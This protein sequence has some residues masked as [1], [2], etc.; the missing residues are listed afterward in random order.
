[1]ANIV[2][3]KHMKLVIQSCLDAQNHAESFLSETGAVPSVT[4]SLKM[5][6]EAV[7]WASVVYTAIAT[8]LTFSTKGLEEGSR[9]CDKEDFELLVVLK[10]FSELYLSDA[11]KAVKYVKFQTTWFTAKLLDQ[12]EF[13]PCP[14]T[15]TELPV[16]DYGF[17]TRRR[18][19]IGRRQKTLLKFDQIS[20]RDNLKD[21]EFKV[22]L[23]MD[24]LM[25]KTGLPAVSEDFVAAALKSTEEG[26]TTLRT[27]TQEQQDIK[28]LVKVRIKQIVHRLFK[29]KQLPIIDTI[30]SMNASYETPHKRGGS[31]G[32]LLS[33]FAA[34]HEGQF[35][36]E[37]LESEL[38]SPVVLASTSPTA[39]HLAQ[40]H[41]I[42]IEGFDLLPAWRDFVTREA[43]LISEKGSADAK[44][45][46]I[47][48]PMKVRTITM[49][50]EVC[51][52]F[53]TMMQKL[54]HRVCKET[55]PMAF[56]GQPLTDDLW[57]KHFNTPL[58]EDEMYCSGDYEAATNNLDPDMSLYCWDCICEEVMVGDK[59][60]S[61]S[62]WH[63]L[64]RKDLCGHLLH[65]G[66]S[67]K[68]HE[69][70]PARELFQVWGQLMGSPTSFPILC[71]VNLAASSLAIG[72]SIE[73]TFKEDCPI[74][75]NGD[76]IICIVTSHLYEVWN[77]YTSAVG[78]KK[79]L[80]KNYISR[81][82]A[83]M[84][85]E[86]RVCEQLKDSVNWKYVPYI[87]QALMRGFE[88]KGLLAGQDLK[89][90]MSY[91][92]LGARCR[93]LVY[94][95][96]QEKAVRVLAEFMREHK[97][98]LER[99]PRNASYWVSEELGGLGLPNLE[100]HSISVEN[101]QT[102]TIVSCM[103]IDDRS[104]ILARPKAKKGFVDG[105]LSESEEHYRKLLPTEERDKLEWDIVLASW[106]IPVERE[107][108]DI[109]ASLRLAYVLKHYLIH[110]CG[111]LSQVGKKCVK[112]YLLGHP[113]RKVSEGNK[114][115]LIDW[116]SDQIFRD[117]KIMTGSKHVD[118][119]YLGTQALEKDAFLWE[120]RKLT[121]K[122][123]KLAQKARKVYPWN[124]ED[125][126]PT[127]KQLLE[128]LESKEN[129]LHVMVEARS[130]VY[131]IPT[132]IVTDYS[133]LQ[134]LV[135]NPMYA[136]MVTRYDVEELHTPP[137]SVEDPI[138]Q[139]I[140][141][142]T[143][144]FPIPKAAVSYP[145]EVTLA[146]PVD[147]LHSIRLLRTT[148]GM[149]ASFLKSRLDAQ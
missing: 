108:S 44:F 116:E 13:P 83:I 89:P 51:T 138:R 135:N 114:V 32:G 76:D 120:E 99:C 47:R 71:L 115:F 75:I 106:G 50:E 37:Y 104:R 79:S 42:A 121:R 57:K 143:F 74:L 131:R 67:A 14:F 113:V 109:G 100:G 97:E 66:K 33:R 24:L 9:A 19:W 98:V 118:V 52:L 125:R 101:L 11:S 64:G 70:T 103:N 137:R 16:E 136:G 56:M 26:L 58:K 107:K 25:C 54:M 10:G 85:S 141:N 60:L 40:D 111:E 84:N 4:R 61:R 6:Q 92:E 63:S 123:E 129:R 20:E 112:A 86:C 110:W 105:L 95:M 27:L 127:C 128:E 80:G 119:S 59:P 69:K 81:F 132:E 31:F 15:T 36:M 3:S 133:C 55:A 65:I 7:Q 144:G 145:P 12:T 38:C 41:K 72:L 102:A 148:S 17:V 139:Q 146:I 147:E 73:D 18:G 88:K 23:A 46:P 87:N 34:E 142:L 117:G 21:L 45:Y 5:V 1:M 53:C 43:T 90:S 22:S 82:F 48:E 91:R 68:G 78:L 149:L 29:G 130:Q 62:V 8:G 35:D 134:H 93:E 49:Q 94:G 126:L 77:Q 124:A 140:T 122:F 2:L 30:P 28:E 39:N 96:H